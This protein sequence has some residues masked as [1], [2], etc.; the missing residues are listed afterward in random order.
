MRA[1][2]INRRFS[3]WRQSLLAA[4]FAALVWLLGCFVASPGLHARLH[5]DAAQSDHVCAIVSFAHGM[6][7]PAAPIGLSA[8]VLGVIDAPIPPH[9]EHFLSAPRYLLQPSRGPPAA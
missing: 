8:A 3:V 7:S 6:T 5:A 9:I 4:V 1:P 2:E